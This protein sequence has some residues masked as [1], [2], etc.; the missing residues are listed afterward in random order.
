MRTDLEILMTA[1][2]HIKQFLSVVKKGKGIQANSFHVSIEV[3][4][5]LDR[6]AGKKLCRNCL[7]EY[8]GATVHVEPTVQECGVQMSL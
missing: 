6:S 1:T 3:S 8:D 7:P 4:L 2:S 5:S